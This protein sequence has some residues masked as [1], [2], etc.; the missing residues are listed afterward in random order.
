[1]TPVLSRRHLAVVAALG[2]ITAS[3][4]QA[5]SYNPTLPAEP[6][7]PAATAVCKTLH[8]SLTQSGGLLPDAVDADPAHSQPDTRQI[9][10]AIDACPSGQ[11]VR[12]VISGNANAFL[13]GPLVLKG[14]VTLWVDNGVTLFASR[15]PKDFDNGG[16]NCG[17]AGGDGKS[18]YALIR[19]KNAADSRVVG[20]GI[21]DGRGGSV[22]TSGANAGKMTWWD[23][24]NLLEATGKK[25]NNP[26]LINLI[27][28]SNFTLYRVT[29][30]NSPNAHVV[31]SG[32]TGFV[33]W[34]TKVLAPSLAYSV[35]HYA[36]AAGTTPNPD[37][38]ATRPSTCFTP[39]TAAN[40]DGIDV[41]ESSN[42]RIAHASIS[43]GDDHIAIK[44]ADAPSSDIYIAH[45]HLYYGHGVSIGSETTRGVSQVRVDDVSI[46]GFDDAQVNGL[47]IKTYDSVGGPVSNVIFANA[48]MRNVK[49]PLI[50]TPY[51]S[52]GNHST[53][54][55]ITDILLQNIH[56]LSSAK[57]GAGKLVFRGYH[58][59]SVT[60][61]LTMTLDNVVFDST[62][63]LTS[64]GKKGGPTQPDYATLTL[65][66]GPVT[67]PFATSSTFKLNDVRAGSRAPLGCDGAFPD[68]PSAN[69]PI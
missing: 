41:V 12:L 68:F 46:D 16:G 49:Q 42:V 39:D 28:G 34:N 53:A 59:G 22:L 63:F 11:A 69:A 24:A 57:F 17:T 32:L 1:M 51:Y 31:V 33:A 64:D 55:N 25:Q 5:A 14:G 58:N 52:S 48:C 6:A 8:A 27:G 45:N 29:L 18:C 67:I 54:P 2:A 35:A 44:A 61:T 66:P 10:D 23:V 40:T 56:V 30:Q 20:D 21:I 4:A 43:T 50:F 37:V 13:S 26:R 47:R 7:L 38:A 19:L 9:Q 36:C 15:S 62:N 3:A 65:G 60:N